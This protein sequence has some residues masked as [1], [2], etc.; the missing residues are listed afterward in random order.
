MLLFQSPRLVAAVDELGSLVAT[1]H[2]MRKYR[3]NV[4]GQNLLTEVD[5]VRQ[6]LGLYTNVFIE[7]LTPGD[8]ES[9]AI[10][11]VREVGIATRRSFGR[12]SRTCSMIQ[13]SLS[14]SGALT[15]GVE[16]MACLTKTT[17]ENVQ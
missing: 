15:I 12:S 5:G 10:E 9:R 16:R 8:A 3:V 17:N 7:A 6:R 2:V 4:H 13:P 1:S 14:T 11:L